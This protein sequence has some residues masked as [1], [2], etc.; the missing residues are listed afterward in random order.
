MLRWHWAQ[1]DAYA[2]LRPGQRV[3]AKQVPY[4]TDFRYKYCAATNQQVLNYLRFKSRPRIFEQL[5]IDT[6]PVPHCGPACAYLDCEYEGDGPDPY[7]LTRDIERELA[8]RIRE[9]GWEGRMEMRD[10]YACAEG[11]YSAHVVCYGPWFA[12]IADVGALVRRWAEDEAASEEKRFTVNG[13]FVIDLGVYTMHRNFRLVGNSKAKAWRPLVPKG[14]STEEAKERCMEFLV[15]DNEPHDDVITV[16]E[17]DGSP[18]KL[19]GHNKG[20]KGPAQFREHSGT[21]LP[22]APSAPGNSLQGILVDWLR[23]HTGDA[24]VNA[25]G[26]NE[27]TICIA[28]PNT[29]QCAIARREHRS[30]HVY[31]TVDLR[32]SVAHQKCYS[33]NCEGHAEIPFPPHVAQAL[34][35]STLFISHTQP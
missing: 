32:R 25:V 30:N 35:I 24:S 18:A 31:F 21:V 33:S 22:N 17:P 7:T 5:L 9:V 6:D 12:S 14:W 26:R 23:K 1:D 19:R 34:Q 29:T 27:T 28:A 11:K 13:E 20:P 16:T 8:R 10:A 3:W 15:Q 4:K 2:A